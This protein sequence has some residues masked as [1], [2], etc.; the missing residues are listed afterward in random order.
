MNLPLEL[1]IRNSLTNP[2]NPAILVLLLFQLCCFALQRPALCL[3]SACLF[4][5]GKAI[6]LYRKQVGW[7]CWEAILIYTSHPTELFSPRKYSPCT[8]SLHCAS[9]RSLFTGIHT[10][11]ELM[12]FINEATCWGQEHIGIHDC[13]IVAGMQ[14]TAEDRYNLFQILS[15]DWVGL[16]LSIVQ[17]SSHTKCQEELLKR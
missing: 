1:H 12:H 17:C 5:D 16:Y 10:H 9:E 15:A 14:G 13:V 6:F 2:H 7:S 8:P 4:C 11:S 3:N